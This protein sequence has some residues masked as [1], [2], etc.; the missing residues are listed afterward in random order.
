MNVLFFLLPKSRD[1][2]ELQEW[3]EQKV[4]DKNVG[5]WNEYELM[6]EIIYVTGKLVRWFKLDWHIYLKEYICSVSTWHVPT[7]QFYLFF[8]SHWFLALPFSIHRH[9]HHLYF[10]QLLL[11]LPPLT[12]VA[13]QKH[14]FLFSYTFWNASHKFWNAWQMVSSPKSQCRKY[15]YGYISGRQGSYITIISWTNPK[16]KV[17]HLMWSRVTLIAPSSWSVSISVKV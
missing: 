5:D 3:Q 14:G 2:E 6:M 16:H 17:H 8:F 7:N 12:E 4:I 11:S 9:F 10:Y 15:L 13:D 1:C